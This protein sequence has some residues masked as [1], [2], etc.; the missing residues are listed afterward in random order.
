MDNLFRFINIAEKCR[1][2]SESEAKT[3]HEIRDRANKI[4]DVKE[5]LTMP[6]ETNTLNI[7]LGYYVH[8]TEV[9]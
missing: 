8:L 9:V 1:L 3:A 5:S 6:S 7:I 4:L 2:L